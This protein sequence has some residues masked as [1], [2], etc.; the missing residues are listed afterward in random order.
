MT[1]G[2]ASITM[3]NVAAQTILLCGPIAEEGRPAR[4]GFESSNLRL[5]GVLN[6]MGF[7]AHGISYPNMSG[8]S[9][10]KKSLSYP[11]SFIKMAVSILTNTRDKTIIVHYTPLRGIFLP[12]ELAICWISKAR[13]A[14]LIIDLRAGSQILQYQGGSAL[15]RLLYRKMLRFADVIAYEGHKYKEF[16]AS[17]EPQKP[18]YLL[19]NFVPEKFLRNVQSNA[20]PGGPHLI[21][22]GRISQDKG[23]LHAVRVFQELKNELSG[24]TLTLIGSCDPGCVQELASVSETGLFTTGPLSFDDIARHLEKSHFF[25]FLTLWKGEGHSNALTEAMGKGCVPV[26]TDHGF[27][28]T[29]VGDCGYIVQDR[30]D[31]GVIVS[32]IKKTWEDGSWEKLSQ[33]ANIRVEKYFSERSIRDTL[34]KMYV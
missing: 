20:R 2:N 3:S 32:L 6:K 5:L 16:I 13:K 10:I 34:K 24:S 30:G 26:C 33:E 17:I 11:L 22:V 8:A 18:S 1:D 25:L 14:K 31:I 27:N 9:L 12:L 28:G 19:P 23:V 15:Y 29:I 7:D 21:Y 4:G